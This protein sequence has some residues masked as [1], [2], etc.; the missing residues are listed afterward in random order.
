M[1]LKVTSYVRSMEHAAEYKNI[2]GLNYNYEPAH[3]CEKVPNS[4][5]RSLTS[6]LSVS[7]GRWLSVLVINVSPKV[8]C[9]GFR[10]FLCLGH[11]SIHLLVESTYASHHS[12]TFNSPRTIIVAS[13]NGRIQASERRTRPRRPSGHG[14]LSFEHESQM[15][16]T[17]SGRTSAIDRT[18]A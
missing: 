8:D 14:A 15:G 3:H 11:G 13:E 4:M 6:S 10:A 18:E 7:H 1:R 2:Q 5:K 12:L 17:R 9:Q 16:G